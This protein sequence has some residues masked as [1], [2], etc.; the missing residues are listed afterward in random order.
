[1]ETSE[2]AYRF[3]DTIIKQEIDLYG[4]Y[5]KLLEK[6]RGAVVAAQSDKV[7]VINSERQEVVEQMRQCQDARRQYLRKFSADRNLKLTDFIN[8]YMTPQDAKRLMPQV[9]KLRL[10]VTR[11]QAIT[12]EAHQVV[13]FALRMISGLTSIIWSATQNV[14]RSYSPIG[15]MCE[16]FH[17][18]GGRTAG[19]L[20]EA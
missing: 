11:A 13:G 5:L 16:A 19:V 14:V 8:R 20:K 3:L 15:T 7:L 2:Q 12:G 9:E 6:E 1:M 10:A 17:R 18:N 4:R